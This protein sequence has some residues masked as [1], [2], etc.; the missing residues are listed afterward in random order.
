MAWEEQ[1]QHGSAGD[2]LRK[3]VLVDAPALCKS[4]DLAQRHGCIDDYR[5]RICDAS[6]LSGDRFGMENMESIHCSHLEEHEIEEHAHYITRRHMEERAGCS[7]LEQPHADA[8]NV[9]RTTVTPQ[10]CQQVA[11]KIVEGKTL[12]SPHNACR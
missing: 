3:L 2:L 12:Q 9:C 4:H 8:R 10:T 11:I 6:T 7:L 1:Q 5:I